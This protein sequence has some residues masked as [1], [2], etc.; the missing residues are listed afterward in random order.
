MKLSSNALSI[1]KFISSHGGKTTKGHI[2]SRYIGSSFNREER[3][4]V[5]QE[6][7]NRNLIATE[8]NEIWI[9]NPHGKEF[10]S[11]YDLY[12]SEEILNGNFQFAILKFLYEVDDKIHRDDLP[13]IFDTSA[14]P[15]PSASNGFNLIYYL[16][17][18]PVM[19]PFVK[20]S[21]DTYELTDLGKAKY[22]NES[23][24]R[25]TKKSILA[26]KDDQESQI[27]HLT[28]MEKTHTV[29][30]QPLETNLKKKTLIVAIIAIAITIIIAVVNWNKK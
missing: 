8:R 23:K 28:I 4:K 1:L 27:R 19:K 18:D 16:E 11:N 24:S 9:T 7:I 26:L 14:P 15:Q 20:T 17:V 5:I 29:I 21:I 12:E 25:L 22:E 3:E 10:L 2:T 13:N 6:L 30:N